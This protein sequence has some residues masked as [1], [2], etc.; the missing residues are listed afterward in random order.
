MRVRKDIEFKTEDGTTL[1]GWHYAP[2]FGD[3]RFPTIVMA[4]GFSAVKELLLD[5]FA[6]AFVAAGF[7]AVVYDHRNLGASDGLPRQHIDPWQQVRDWRDAITYAETLPQTDAQRIGVWG[8]SYAGAH[9]MVLGAQDRRVRCVV[10]Q[11][12]LTSGHAN[13]RRLV[14]ADQIVVMQ[15]A[16][17]ED[18]RR[19]SRG[20]PAQLIPV[21]APEGQPSALPT[22]DS[23]SWMTSRAKEHAP[24]WRNEVTLQSAELFS[25][26]E[27][28]AYV[29]FVS[30]TPLLMVVALDDELAVADEALKTYAKA[31]EPKRLEG[32]R[33]GHF[34]VY[35]QYFSRSSGAAV[36]WFIEHL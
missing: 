15:R 2:S 12:P 4:H 3:G 33:C 20:E 11:V 16:F 18:R 1:R 7:A 32:I 28:G 5:R 24:S 36:S 19:R 6:E 34:D 26:Y 30:P 10:A 35:D 9:A 14:R 17:D 31:L 23:Y 8:S 21:V 13:F 22:P 29:E 27:P 25:E